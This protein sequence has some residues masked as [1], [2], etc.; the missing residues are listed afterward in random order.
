MLLS[1]IHEF[2][3]S[4]Y[5]TTSDPK[6]PESVPTHFFGLF[7]GHAGGRCSKFISSTL[8]EVL[9]QDSL[10]NSNLPMALKRSFHT[11]NDSFLKI[12]EQQRLHDGSTGI[13]SIIRNDKLLVGNV[14]DCRSLLLS[15]GKPIQMS[16]D[17]KPTNPE[18]VKRIISLGGTI[19]NNLGV[20]RVNGVLAVSRAFGNR[21]L[22]KVIRPDIEMMQRDLSRDDDFLIMA[23]DGLWDVLRN[24]DVC[25][26]SYSLSASHLPQQI[27]EELVHSAIARGSMD[28]VTCIVVKLSEYAASINKDGDYGT[29]FGGS[30]L[31]RTNVRSQSQFLGTSHH[32]PQNQSRGTVSQSVS[33]P[34]LDSLSLDF[35]RYVNV[36]NGGDNNHWQSNCATGSSSSKLD[37]VN[38]GLVVA[39]RPDLCADSDMI[40][41]ANEGDR[42]DNGPRGRGNAEFDLSEGAALPWTGSRPSTCS[43]R[44]STCSSRPSTC[45]SQDPTTPSKSFD[46]TRDQQAVGQI[47]SKPTYLQNQQHQLLGGNYFSPQFQRHTCE[48]DVERAECDVDD[49]KHVTGRHT[50]AGT[51]TNTPHFINRFSKN[52]PPSAFNRS[53]QFPLGSLHFGG[54]MNQDHRSGHTPHKEQVWCKT[55]G[56]RSVLLPSNSRASSASAASVRHSQTISGM[57]KLFSK[58]ASSETFSMQLPQR[59]SDLPFYP[60][61]SPPAYTGSVARSLP[62]SFG[63]G[64]LPGSGQGQGPGHCTQ[65]LYS[66]L[67]FLSSTNEHQWS[68]SATQRQKFP[69]SRQLSA[70]N[71]ANTEKNRG[72][73]IPN[74]ELTHMRFSNS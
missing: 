57:P 68:G 26:I 9:A 41:G 13:C 70:S 4:S 67:A 21:K 38:G 35:S 69:A 18:E 53:Q 24:K 51:G 63:S 27:A 11:T 71:K 64:L 10:F 8:P 73:L 25:D 45:N 15:A 66:S 50:S 49:P 32:T 6:C 72:L 14:G 47:C 46:R 65:P 58:A 23:S 33:T 62:S 22:R 30:Y 36:F 19:T 29:H 48:T 44:P 42:G 2:L 3:G 5:G 56:S 7:D 54:L 39:T 34:G 59:M 20:A 61:E 16:I 17:Q 12:A 28:N 40:E 74:R 37:T 43:S 52:L 60:H 55:P 1:Q 31:D